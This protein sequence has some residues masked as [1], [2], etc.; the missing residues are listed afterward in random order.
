[1]APDDESNRPR[2]PERPEYTVY[3]SRPRLLDRLRRKDR[4]QLGG[5]RPEPDRPDRERR[6]GLPGGRPPW[7]R[8]LK[9]VGIAA[10][11][12]LLLS[13][14]AF[15]VSAQIQKSKLADG[16][17]AGAAPLMPLVSQTILVLGTDI[18][19]GQFAGA[20][21]AETKRCLEEVGGG[22]GSHR[23]CRNAPYRSDT[24]MLIRAGGG[25]F[26]QLSL[27]RDTLAEIPGVGVSKVNAAYANGG[28]ELVKETV[29]QYLG[30]DINQ[31]AIVDFDGF[32]KFIDTLGGVKVNLTKRV[33]ST[34]SGGAFQLD[35]SPGEHTLN[36]YQAI[37]LARTR[38]AGDCNGDGAPDQNINDL[39]RAGFQQAIVD[40]IKGRL[41]SITRL[42]IN[43]IKG[44][45]LGWNAPKAMVSSMGA[46]TMPELVVAAAIGGSET[47]RM[48]P[49]SLDPLVFSDDE[50]RRAARRFLGK[51]PP[52][53]PACSP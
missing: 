3:R 27:P 35:L 21:E 26:R 42:P 14:A 7:R 38:T 25:A 19:S 41:T 8:I 5:E 32:R 34:V 50:C 22:V 12:W 18:R 6:P 48:E 53:T 52:R 33:C 23:S 39:D 2:P 4:D 46:I 43:F 47:I 49:S 11:A 10:L 51:Q 40:G 45:I 24:I 28:A 20:A 16:V 9:W 15:A 13:I 30:L 29:E 37:T 1:M 44:P 36:G 31:V 17:D